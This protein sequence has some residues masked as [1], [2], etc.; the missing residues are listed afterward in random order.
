MSQR[1]LIKSAETKKNTGKVI[2]AETNLKQYTPPPPGYHC[3][4]G[5]FILKS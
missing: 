5:Y 4:L 1:K 3:Y 2:A